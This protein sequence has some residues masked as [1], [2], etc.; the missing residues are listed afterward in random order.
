MALEELRH[1]DAA[2]AF[3]NQIDD[4]EKGLNWLGY[5]EDTR[6]GAA[7]LVKQFEDE[8][9]PLVSAG[10]IVPSQNIVKLAWSDPDNQL[11]VA[12]AIIYEYDEQ[13]RMMEDCLLLARQLS[14]EQRAE[15]IRTYCG[16]RG[17]AWE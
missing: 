9:P 4:P 10:V 14:D 12:A 6:H 1:P 17:D 16:D 7:E 8:H 13:N 2:P 3:F 11:K 5:F 15:L